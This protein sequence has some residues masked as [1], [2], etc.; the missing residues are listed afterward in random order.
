M[1][2]PSTLLC[3]LIWVAAVLLLHGLPDQASADPPDRLKTI[4]VND[5]YDTKGHVR[6]QL[7]GP[8]HPKVEKSISIRGNLAVGATFMG[9]RYYDYPVGYSPLLKGD[10]VPV[11]GYLYRVT[12][13]GAVTD[14]ISGRKTYG[15]LLDWIKGENVPPGIALRPDSVA[16][17]LQRHKP[18]G[19]VLLIGYMTRR[20][21]VRVVLEAI[22][23]VEG[24]TK[25]FMA[26][27]SQN[28][29]P[30]VDQG[31][32]APT[33]KVREGDILMV[34][35]KSK[36]GIGYADGYLVRRIVPPDETTGV[37][38]WLE[39]A[40]RPVDEKELK[41]QADRVVRPGSR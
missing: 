21:Y 32:N 28:E 33:A 14:P 25:A 24:D 11:Y 23:P 4:I 31:G 3:R 27:V 10:I 39:L 8:L 22:E 36:E 26:R 37:I 20:N 38:G 15:L 1:S 13:V 18:G 30:G 17:P 29:H 5:S 41:K 6:P 35:G 34:E 7:G 9:E 40:P 16:V 19:W 2:A 12:D